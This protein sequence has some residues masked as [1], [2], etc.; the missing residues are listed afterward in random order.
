MIYAVT[1]VYKTKPFSH[2][3]DQVIFLLPTIQGG[4]YTHTISI[5][6]IKILNN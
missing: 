4:S 1:F 2:I 3:E 6:G 5:V